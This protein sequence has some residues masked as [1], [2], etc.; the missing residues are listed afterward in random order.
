M[1]NQLYELIALC[2]KH[3]IFIDFNK[4]GVTLHQYLGEYH[5]YSKMYS[6]ELVNRLQDIEVIVNDFN[7]YVEE[8]QKGEQD[9]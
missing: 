1:S 3:D 2:K 6:L 5:T 4:Y 8:R 9:G 7:Q